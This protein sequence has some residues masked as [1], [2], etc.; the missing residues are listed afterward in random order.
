[1]RVYAGTLFAGALIISANPA[2]A[3]C[4]GRSVGG[5][6]RIAQNDTSHVY[7][8][9]QR[10]DVCR[11]RLSSYSSLQ[12]ERVSV[13]SPARNG[14]ASVA[15]SGAITYM[16]KAGFAGSD[17]FTLQVCGKS[18]AGSGCSTIHYHVTIN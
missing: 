2:S 18:D 6:F 1:M 7:V 16:P 10:G 14:N 11:G 12:I 8:T 9:G 17:G 5:G 3:E 4:T 13:V 15:Q